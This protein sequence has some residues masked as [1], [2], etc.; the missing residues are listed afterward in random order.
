MVV[1]L[2]DGNDGVLMTR[3]FSAVPIRNGYKTT[4]RG[5]LFTGGVTAAFTVGD[6]SEYE[7]VEF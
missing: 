3:T 1:T 7:V 5:Q 2:Y 6:W 4:Y